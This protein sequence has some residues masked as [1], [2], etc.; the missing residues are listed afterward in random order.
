M[1]RRP[2]ILRELRWSTPV[3]VCA[4][5]AAIIVAVLAAHSIR[6]AR[7][8][9]PQATVR[10]FLTTAVVDNN[11]PVACTYLTQA[12]QVSAA[13]TRP[14]VAPGCD[15]FFNDA[16]LTL[17]GL[18][19]QSNADLNQLSYRV[20]PRGADRLV[21][22]GHGGQR[23]SFLLR[24]ADAAGLAE[25]RPPPTGWRVTS[26]IAVLGS[27]RQSFTPGNRGL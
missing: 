18:Q 22:V 23:I 8:G 19:V 9:T 10:D 6:V 7:E 26:G 1:I 21:E 27:G 2:R 25:F 20:V 5:A 16:G 24:P 3:F 4:F 17:G 13:G 15:I 14:G 11:G 12:A